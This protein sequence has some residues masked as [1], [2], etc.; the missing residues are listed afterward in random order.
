MTRAPL[1]ER[2]RA[3]VAACTIGAVGFAFVSPLVF[4]RVLELRL[5]GSLSAIDW[6]RVLI[7]AVPPCLAIAALVI[8]RREFVAVAIGVTSSVALSVASILQF[9][10]QGVSLRPQDYAGWIGSGVMA[11]C[12]LVAADLF[13]WRWGSRT[14]ALGALAGACGGVATILVVAYELLVTGGFHAFGLVPAG[15]WLREFVAPAVLLVV[16]GAIAGAVAH[17]LGAP[18]EAADPA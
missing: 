5:P 12:G 2:D 17:G 6:V 11:A 9:A 10:G 14:P 3:V 1:A 8:T 18:Q 15:D 4:G 13:V 16:V 7:A